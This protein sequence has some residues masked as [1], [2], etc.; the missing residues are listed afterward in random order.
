[1]RL[2][3]TSDWHLG[4]IDCSRYLLEDQMHFI[5]EICGII[6]AEEIEAV[7]IAGDIYD[8]SVASSEAIRMYDRA[9]TRICL[10]M[11]VPA[12][13][14]AGNHDGA[15][16]LESCS[17]L[18][19]AAGLY[20]CGVIRRDISKACFPDTDIY[21]L[22]WITEEK[23][24]S[25]YPDKKDQISSLEDAYRI[26]SGEMKKDFDPGKRH[27]LLAHAYITDSETSVSDKAA[28]IGTAT[29]ISAQIFDDFD[30]VAL[31]HIHKPQDVSDSI[32]YSGTPMAY[33]FGKE[34]TQE[35]SVTVIDTLTMERRII[36]L[37]PLHRRTTLT[38]TLDE[39]MNPR[40]LLHKQARAASAAAARQRETGDL[41][42]PVDPD[43][44]EETIKGY[45]KLRVTDKPVGLSS[46]MQLR[47]IYPKL[48]ECE[49][50]SFDNSESTIRLTVDE[51]EE[52]QTDPGLVFES[53]CREICGMQPDDHLKGL[54]ERAVMTA[55]EI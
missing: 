15:E 50:L 10:E 24:K 46:L 51:Y 11:H 54:F 29:Q 34:E 13:V 3:H 22:P 25:I 7:L 39:L 31:G 36:P 17:E 38:G 42:D 47:E 16:R 35:K 26:A 44:I 19:K 27:V 1:M 6:A 37:H 12:V 33:S 30:Y 14:I 41:C 43:I 28:V 40:E 20:V 49:S 23:V 9:M 52:M 18:L 2:L 21:L 8:R 53:F 4:A 5:D 45:V 55:E 48:L 32:R